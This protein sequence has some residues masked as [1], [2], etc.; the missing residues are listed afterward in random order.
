[1]NIFCFNFDCV[2]ANADDSFDIF[3][4]A[5]IGVNENYN[6][7]PLRVGNRDMVF[8]KKGILHHKGTY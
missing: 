1:M 2:T 8:L 3:F 6:I 5:I 4:R 7:T